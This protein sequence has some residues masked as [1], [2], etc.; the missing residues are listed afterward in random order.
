M[1]DPAGVGPGSKLMNLARGTWKG[2][3][4]GSIDGSDGPGETANGASER[5]EAPHDTRGGSEGKRSG[6]VGR[7]GDSRERE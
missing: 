1:D 6:A 2:D 4:H 5:D 7:G 3:G